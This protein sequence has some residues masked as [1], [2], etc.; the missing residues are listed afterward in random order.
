MTSTIRNIHTPDTAMGKYAVHRQ[1]NSYGGDFLHNFDDLWGASFTGVGG[2]M[3][4][5]SKNEAVSAAIRA[6]KAVPVSMCGVAFVYGAVIL[7]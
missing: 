3:T 5:D 7:V 2:A 1:W 6:K 4:F